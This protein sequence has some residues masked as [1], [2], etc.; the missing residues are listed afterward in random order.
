MLATDCPCCGTSLRGR[1]PN[2]PW[3]RDGVVFKWPWII[4][5]DGCR[6][7]YP[8]RMAATGRL[9]LLAW[10]ARDMDVR[11]DVIVE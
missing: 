4:R 5:C 9:H 6:K 11:P 7:C 10:P 3:R 2:S 1:S 8:V